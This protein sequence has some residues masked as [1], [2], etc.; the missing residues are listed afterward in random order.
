MHLFRLPRYYTSIYLTFFVRANCTYSIDV[1][2]K[3]L[4]RS[5]YAS[6]KFPGSGTGM[7][8]IHIHCNVGMSG[9]EASG[10]PRSAPL[11]TSRRWVKAL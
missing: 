8:K 1:K 2:P 10:H 5:T 7:Q 3:D 9:R 11:D 4:L 6:Q